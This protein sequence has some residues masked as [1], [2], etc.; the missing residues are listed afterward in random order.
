M[1]R[2]EAYEQAKMRVSSFVLITNTEDAKKFPA[3]R[4]LREY[5]QGADIC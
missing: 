4:V 1:M 3:E 2:K 5:K